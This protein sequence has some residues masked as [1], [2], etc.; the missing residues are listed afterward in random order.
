MLYDFYFVR[1]RAV[2]TLPIHRFSARYSRAQLVWVHF[3]IDV[4]VVQVIG[5]I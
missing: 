2:K 1:D 4:S 3:T 5:P